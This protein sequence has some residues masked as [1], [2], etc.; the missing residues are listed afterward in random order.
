MTRGGRERERQRACAPAPRA[1]G[2]ME[3]ESTRGKTRGKQNEKKKRESIGRTRGDAFVYALGVDFLARLEL[4][5]CFF[6][7]ALLTVGTTPPL[8]KVTFLSSEPMSSSW[9]TASVSVRGLRR[10]T[11]LPLCA[12]AFTVSSRSS[13][14]KYSRVAERYKAPEA[15]TR[16]AY[17]PLRSREPTRPTGKMRPAFADLEPDLR[18]AFFA[19]RGVAILVVVGR[20]GGGGKVVCKTAWRER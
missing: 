1:T 14:V 5:L 8:E 16:R 9:R 17:W 3:S 4:F 6:A 12:A 11:F 19:E 18:A 15:L 13:A 7:T 2:G 20:G 10:R